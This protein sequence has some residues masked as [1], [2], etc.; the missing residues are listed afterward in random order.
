M[1]AKVAKTLIGKYLCVNN[2]FCLNW[3]NLLKNIC[4]YIAVL[5]MKFIF[6]VVFESVLCNNEFKRLKSL[7]LLL[8]FCF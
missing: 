8:V 7:E 2:R 4:I 3:V 1:I 6:V 5:C